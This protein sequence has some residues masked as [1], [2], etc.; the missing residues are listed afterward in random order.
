MRG[1]PWD[2][3][4][5]R[6]EPQKEVV[7]KVDPNDEALEPHTFNFAKDSMDVARRTAFGVVVRIV[8][9]GHDLVAITHQGGFYRQVQLLVHV[10]DW[11]KCYE[12]PKQ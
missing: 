2:H 5:N 3:L 7:K 10:L 4:P 6:Y 1:I 11:L 9:M 8:T 12:T